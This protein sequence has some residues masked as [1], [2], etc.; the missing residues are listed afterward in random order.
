MKT[1]A[2][3]ILSF[4]TALMSLAPIV[5]IAKGQPTPH[6]IQVAKCNQ[7]AHEQARLLKQQFAQRDLNED[8]RLDASESRDPRMS[9]VCQAKC[10]DHIDHNRDGAVQISEV[11]RHA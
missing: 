1:P 6:E 8:G 10:H 3:I 5:A 9:A 7:K 2:A 11:G 4:A